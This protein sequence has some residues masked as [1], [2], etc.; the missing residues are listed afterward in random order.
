MAREER[1]L[2]LAQEERQQRRR[3]GL[4][5]EERRQQRRV[6]VAQEEPDIGMEA[7]AKGKG[8]DEMEALGG[9]RT[10]SGPQE[11]MVGG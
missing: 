5:Q 7:R 3:V 6:G 11:V 9:E 2:G 10:P 8:V 4:A 1:R